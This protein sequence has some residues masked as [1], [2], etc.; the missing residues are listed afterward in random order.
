ML[1]TPCASSASARVAPTRPPPRMMTSEFMCI[2]L[3]VA[4]HRA[5]AP[6]GRRAGVVPG[7]GA[8]R[9]VTKVTPTHVFFE[10][11]GLRNRAMASRAQP[12]LLRETVKAGAVRGGAL[13]AA[14]ALFV[15][16]AVMV[17]A[18][19][20]YRASD[21]ALNT[22]SGGPVQ[23][24]AGPPGAWFAD[25]ALTLFGPAVAL[26]LPIAPIVAARLWRDRPAGRWLAMLRNAAIGVALIAA[27]LAFVSDASV[28][29][30]PAGWGGV[31]GLSIAKAVEWGLSFIGQPGAERWAARGIGLI[32]GIAGIVIWAK[33]LDIDLGDRRFRL[34]RTRGDAIGADDDGDDLYD[35]AYDDGDEE[36]LQLARKVV[37]P[38]A[39]ATPDPR[40]APNIADR[41]L[42]PSAAKPKP[43]QQSL[44]LGHSYTLP[45]L[46]LLTPAPPAP[47]GTI[48]KASLERNARLLENCAPA[49]S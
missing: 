17:L 37:E 29:A 10:T 8:V 39:I 20:S 46:D 9:K 23:N 42:A 38:R 24:L 21:A 19:A 41:N 35:D 43:K 32:V 45:Q 5:N 48:D 12:G 31:A 44:D 2:P 36:P 15:A 16:T 1:V 33:S 3:Q 40:P 13:V 25:L 18:L 27:A 14:I 22:A 11:G 30:L 28:L 47:K 4:A 26:L 6:Y 34:R 49:R 7:G